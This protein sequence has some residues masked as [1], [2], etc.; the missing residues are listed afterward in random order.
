MSIR[1]AKLAKLDKK[2]LLSYMSLL[3]LSTKS[4]FRTFIPRAGFGHTEN[5]VEFCRSRSL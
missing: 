3:I 4:H 2:F 1:F 5:S